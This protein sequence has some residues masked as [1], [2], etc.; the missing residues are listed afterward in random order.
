M[1][2][3]DLW[4]HRDA[5]RPLV[6]AVDFLVWQGYPSDW[7]MSLTLRQFLAYLEAAAH[8]MTLA[9]KAGAFPYR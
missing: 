5:D 7:V 2:K 1:Q 4:P 9:A 6:R 8:R 3:T